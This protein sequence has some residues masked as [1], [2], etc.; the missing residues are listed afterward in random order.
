MSKVAESF[1]IE[2]GFLQSLASTTTGFAGMVQTFCAKLGWGNLAILLGGFKERLV[3]GVRSEL[4]EL[5]RL[6]YVK[7]FTAR[8]FWEGGMKSISMIAESG[9]EDVLPLLQKVCL[10]LLRWAEIGATVVSTK[11]N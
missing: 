9:V 11:E 5:A 8:V 4:L 7:G 2:R 6:P 3:F 10:W 1:S